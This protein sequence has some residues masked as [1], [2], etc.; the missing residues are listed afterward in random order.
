MALTQEDMEDIKSLAVEIQQLV[1]GFDYHDSKV[2]ELCYHVDMSMRAI[3]EII[4]G[5][6]GKIERMI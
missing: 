3:L 6:S 5:P 1:V 4:N 2:A